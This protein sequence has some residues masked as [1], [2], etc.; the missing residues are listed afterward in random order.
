[1]WEL[2][3]RVKKY[4]PV[5]KPYL[6]FLRKV[7]GVLFYL[8]GELLKGKS[9]LEKAFSYY[10]S[11]GDNV[12]TME[13]Y[14]LILLWNIKENQFHFKLA[15]QKLDSVLGENSFLVFKNTSLLHQQYFK[16]KALEVSFLNHMSF[17]IG[18][19]DYS[20][21]SLNRKKI[22]SCL[23]FMLYKFPDPINREKMKRLFWN[24]VDTDGRDANLRVALSTLNKLLVEAVIE[25]FFESRN[26]YIYLKNGY[27]IL[28]DIKEFNLLYKKGQQ[29]YKDGEFT[30]CQKYFKTFLNWMKKPFVPLG[31]EGS[32]EWQ[33]QKRVYNLI[34]NMESMMLDMAK[35]NGRWEE[36]EL[37]CRSL[38][39]KDKRYGNALQSILLKNKKENVLKSHKEMVYGEKKKSLDCKVLEKII[40]PF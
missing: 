35:K 10:L 15:I 34:L 25:P 13:T 29:Y 19:V 33:L 6:A 17:R 39:E 27:K 8:K 4:C 38:Y 1:M 12:N 14:L 16:I 24:T 3:R 2:A 20:A 30:E 21:F 26:G 31:K 23:Y 28:A 9:K 7:E 36:V 5:E 18:G 11:I 22:R 32:W 40:F 37:Y